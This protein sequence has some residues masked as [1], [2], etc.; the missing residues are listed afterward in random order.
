MKSLLVIMLAAVLLLGWAGA[1]TSYIRAPAVL[2]NADNGILTYVSL[3][4]TPGHGMVYVVG[5]NNVGSSTTDSAITAAAYASEYLGYNENNYTFKYR[6]D[7]SSNI[8]GP[9]AGL[10]FTLLAISALQHRPLADNFTVTGTI[11]SNGSVGEIGGV[12]NKVEAAKEQGM[13]FVL[14]PYAPPYSF[15]EEFY[16]IAQQH[17][18]V[19]LVEVANVTQ[20]LP[21]AFGDV[22][23][24]PLSFNLSENYSVGSLPATNLTCTACNNSAFA[25]LANYTLNATAAEVNL[26]S[27][28]YSAVKR[29]MMG[30][31]D[32]YRQ[33]GA[34]GYLYS[35][36]DLAYLEYINA[37]MFANSGNATFAHALQV[38]ENL[39]TYCTSLAPPP[40]TSANYEYVIGGEMRQTWGE[41]NLGYSEQLLNQSE[42][43]DGVLSSLDVAASSAG[44]CNAANQ[45]YRIAT[46]IGGTDYVNTSQSIKALAASYIQSPD[47]S[48][49]M[50][51]NAA[52]QDYQEG[53]YG[54]ALYAAVYANTFD[55]Q[56]RQFNASP[57]SAGAIASNLSAYNYGVWPSQ[58][59]KQ[60][61]FYLYEAGLST[62]ASNRSAYVYSAYTTMQ[63]AQGLQYANRQITASFVHST[64][65]LYQAA[66][67]GISVEAQIT[68]IK[69]E[70]SQ[71]YY[72]LLILLVVVVIM[73]IVMIAQLVRAPGNGTR[74]ET[75][76][77]ARGRRQSD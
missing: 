51:K 4:V 56:S 49:G 59:A 76:R 71:V 54:A 45:M 6:I 29:Q 53:L 19:P 70:I 2:L 39:D 14:V 33:L 61:Q 42:S 44:W 67:T 35:A 52:V 22:S 43:S 20:A 69:V 48:N 18:N 46:R 25:L 7:N 1:Y 34:K 21:Y 58:F 50:Y 47:I 77:A 26:L 8:S 65:P 36:S 37:F 55:N 15:E 28:N 40:M 32:Q 12:Y 13:R 24:E 38:M 11:A 64:T 3:N 17:F 9:S 66:P 16:Y 63:L 74:N 30:Q 62:N 57:I 68:G 60:S 5:P 73:L 41:I 10:A 72:I 31:L 27:D 75:K 23:P